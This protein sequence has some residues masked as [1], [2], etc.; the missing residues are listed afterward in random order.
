M[1]QQA[2]LVAG[3]SAC[4]G[5]LRWLAQ[6][7]LD[8]RWHDWWWGTLAVNLLGC[9]AIGL[10]AAWVGDRSWVRLLLMTGVLGGFTTFSAFGV[11]TIQLLQQQRWL[12][13]VAYV[14]LSVLGGLAATWAGWLLGRQLPG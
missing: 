12:A 4:G 7:L 13:A 10:L 6:L 5:V 9:L 1:L 8:R 14:A 3:G 11:Q 2:L